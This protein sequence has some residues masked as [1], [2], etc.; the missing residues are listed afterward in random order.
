VLFRSGMNYYIELEQ[1]PLT[2]DQALVAIVKNL[3]NEQ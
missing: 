1:I 2:E 3:R